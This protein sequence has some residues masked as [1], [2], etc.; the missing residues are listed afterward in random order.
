MFLNVNY[1]FFWFKKD[2]HGWKLWIKTIVMFF[3]LAFTNQNFVVRT[4]LKKGIIIIMSSFRRLQCLE[5]IYFRRCTAQCA[6]SI[7]LR[8]RVRRRTV[9]SRIISLLVLSHKIGTLLLQLNRR[10]LFFFKWT[11]LLSQNINY[12]YSKILFFNCSQPTTCA[13]LESKTVPSKWS[14]ERGPT[15]K[16][17]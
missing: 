11:K 3:V 6:I 16:S 17:D 8:R 7:F 10:D 2:F 4:V 15:G 12:S 9:K 13:E 14:R 1:Y 5:G